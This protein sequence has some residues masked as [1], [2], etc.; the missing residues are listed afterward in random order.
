MSEL[1]PSLHAEIILLLKTAKGFRIA[2]AMMTDYVVE[3]LEKELP[4]EC[5]KKYLV[6]IDLPTHPD[7][8]TKLLD[9]RTA[10]PKFQARVYKAKENYH[11]KVYIIKHKDDTYTTLLGSANATRGGWFSNVE[12]NS[13]HQG[14]KGSELIQW[15]DDLFSQGI[16][17]DD[18]FIK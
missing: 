1:T 8:L 16:E 4:S 14:E 9:F 15:F 5:E 7:V 11:P 2:V 3:I 10:K 18:I 13:I 17:F 6:G 12:M